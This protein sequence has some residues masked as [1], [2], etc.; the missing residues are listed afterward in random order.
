V[1]ARP[2]RAIVEAPFAA[3]VTEQKG[4]KVNYLVSKHSVRKIPGALL[5]STGPDAGTGWFLGVGDPIYDA[6]DPRWGGQ[7]RSTDFLNLLQTLAH[8]G[9][10]SGAWRAIPSYRAGDAR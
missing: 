8:G 6:A 10:G 1:V 5:L 7:K 4:G 3:L 9:G 2:R